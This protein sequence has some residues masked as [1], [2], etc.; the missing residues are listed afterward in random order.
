MSIVC[1]LLGNS[2]AC[3]VQTLGNYPEESKQRS[4]HSESLKS[5]ISMTNSLYLNIMQPEPFGGDIHITW[6]SVLGRSSASDMVL[7]HCSLK[8]VSESPNSWKL[9][10]RWGEAS[11]PG[12]TP[13][14]GLSGSKP[15]MNRVNC[16]R[17][18]W[19]REPTSDTARYERV[20]FIYGL[21][22]LSDK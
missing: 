2:P 22:I 21:I 13:L 1:F 3:E 17:W 12:T 20:A 9:P 15:S 14:C 5:R 18:P 6:I 4:E 11:E 16:W 10:T 7:I 8:V 19:V